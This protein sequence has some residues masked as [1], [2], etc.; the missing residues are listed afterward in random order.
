MK[1]DKLNIIILALCFVSTQL[2]SQNT[3]P[4]VS[5]VEFVVDGT[6]ITVTYDVLDTE[7]DVFTVYMEVSEDAGTHWGFDYGD[8]SGDI[9]EDVT[10]GTDKTITFSYSGSNAGTMKIR[11]LANDLYGD[12]IYYSRT[13]YNT[14]T[15]GSQVWLKENLNV[16]TMIT[17]DGTHTGQQQTDNSIIEKYCYNNDEANCTTY[18][19]LYEWNEAMQYSTT[20]GV[21]GICPTGW[22]IPSRDEWGVLTTLVGG[23]GATKL[24]DEN[25]KSGYS[26]TN[27]TGFSVLFAG[28]RQDS[29]GGF[30]GLTD[31][32]IFWTSTDYTSATTARWMMLYY[33]DDFV[34]SNSQ[35]KDFGHS[36][37]C[38]KN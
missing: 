8:A 12:Q 31:R 33:N 35:N 37:R 1:L 26:Y 29:D 24:I 14:V 18:G 15:I 3:N 4:I 38:I 11:I 21:Q 13:I 19:G 36:I 25:A 22:H 6:T 2:L 34:S 9:G 28:N 17:S 20:E 7:D 16:G 10:E 5:N 30:H 27:E 32:G 23:T